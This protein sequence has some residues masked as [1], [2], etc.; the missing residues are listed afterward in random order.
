M[1]KVDHMTEKGGSKVD[2]MT[3]ES[4]LHDKERWIT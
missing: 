3:E 1:T 2:H 4:G